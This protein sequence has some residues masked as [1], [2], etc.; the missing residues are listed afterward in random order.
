MGQKSRQSPQWTHCLSVARSSSIGT[1]GPPPDRPSGRACR[2][3]RVCA[4]GPPSRASS[5]RGY[6]VPPARRDQLGGL[7][8]VRLSAAYTA[9]DA[10]QRLSKGD[11]DAGR[12]QR[13]AAASPSQQVA[14]LMDG[15]LTTQVLYVAVKLGIAEVLAAGPSDAETLA[16]AVQAQPAALRRILRGLAAEEPGG[17][18]GRALRPDRAR[19]VP[20]RRRAGLAARGDHR[21]GRRLRTVRRPGLLAAVQQGGTAFERVRGTTFFEYLGQ[22][23]ELGPRSRARWWTRHAR[24]P[25]T[26]SPRTILVGMRHWWTWAAATTSC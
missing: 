5:W 16:S 14:R 24:R 19:D 26:W 21:A 4:R 1:A 13:P 20:A 7:R 6:T 15:Y 3:P 22:H 11:R 23:P 17:A 10:R 12:M 8:G 18:P 2:R 9:C 25:P